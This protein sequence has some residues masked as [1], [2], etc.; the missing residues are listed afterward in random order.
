LR[1]LGNYLP[2]LQRVLTPQRF[3][4]SLGVMR[5]MGELADV[6]SLDRRRA[7]TAGLLHDAAKDLEPEQQ[8][9]LAKAANVEFRYPC[10]RLPVYLHG[11]ASACLVSQELGV[12]DRSILDA[13]SAH[14]FCGGGASFNSPFSWCL[15]FAD[16]LAPVQEWTGM[17][18]LKRVVYAGQMEEAALLQIGWLIEYF[19]QLCIP[20]HPN[21]TKYFQQLSA[22]LGVED[23]FFERW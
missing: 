18:K 14:T 4:H 15:R 22:D 12:T 7:V 1:H 21:L 10:E 19:R 23:S 9:A 6:Y 16:I 11:P 3:E 8:M 2:F 5:L 17:K 20:L 13:I